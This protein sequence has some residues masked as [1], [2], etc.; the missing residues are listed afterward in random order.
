MNCQCQCLVCNVGGEDICDLL[1]G[2]PTT[3]ETWRPQVLLPEIQTTCLVDSAHSAVLEFLLLWSQHYTP[4][5][6]IGLLPETFAI[7]AWYLWWEGD[8]S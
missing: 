5:L 2:C 4:V 3:R 8:K 6:G 1:F 7:G